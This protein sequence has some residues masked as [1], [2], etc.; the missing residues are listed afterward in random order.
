MVFGDN[1]LGSVPHEYK[2]ETN[3]IVKLMHDGDLLDMLI[4][5]EMQQEL[6]DYSEKM[7]MYYYIH[8][9]EKE[10]KERGLD[11]KKTR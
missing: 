4:R 3:W 9:I 11:A 10:I 2:K 6:E 5:L 1:D 7:R 8:A